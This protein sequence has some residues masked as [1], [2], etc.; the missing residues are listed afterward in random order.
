[1]STLTASQA[2]GII[3]AL[4]VCGAMVLVLGGAVAVNQVQ[5]RKAR[6]AQRALRDVMSQLTAED[7][8]KAGG[9]GLSSLAPHSVFEED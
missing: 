5:S 7:V 8:S 2:T 9:H 4:C 6:A 3:L 1:M